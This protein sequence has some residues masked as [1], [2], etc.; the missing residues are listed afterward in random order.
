MEIRKKVNLGNDQNTYILISGDEVLV[1][2]PGSDAKSI[3]DICGDKIKYIVLTHCHYDHIEGL[4]ELKEKTGAKI[5]F[6]KVGKS[7]LNDPYVNLSEMVYEKNIGLEPDILVS[8]ND[9]LKLGENEILC[10]ETPG[11][12][13][14]GMCYLTEK[15]LFSGDTLFNNSIGRTDLPTGNYSVLEGSVKNKI[16]TLADD[17]EVYPGHGGVTTVGKEKKYNSFIRG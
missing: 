11:H 8:D 14:C 15:Y 16:Y 2:D 1:I 10:I 4:M 5:V 6:S 17:I 9:V 7:N 13:S 3:T 12:T